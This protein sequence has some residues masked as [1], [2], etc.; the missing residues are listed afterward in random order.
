M[1]NRELARE[2]VRGL[3]L[4]PR[5]DTRRLS[6]ET[7]RLKLAEVEQV[8]ELISTL[9]E[10]LASPDREEDLPKQISQLC[11]ERYKDGSLRSA[12]LERLQDELGIEIHMPETEANLSDTELGRRLGHELQ[13][14]LRGGEL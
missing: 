2:V 6:E 12:D 4:T 5:S 14:K 10:L 11:Y 7:L 13:R 3:G 1:E 9:R 8:D